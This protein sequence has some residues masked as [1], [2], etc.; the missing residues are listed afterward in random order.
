MFKL[1]E[2]RERQHQRKFIPLEFQ[3]QTIIDTLKKQY[4]ITI[5]LPKKWKYKNK[6]YLKGYFGYVKDIL[7]QVKLNKSIKI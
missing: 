4:K 7:K 1:K 3:I 6:K 2:Q 5:Q